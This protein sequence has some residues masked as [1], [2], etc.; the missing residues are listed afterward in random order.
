MKKI[1]VFTCLSILLLSSEAAWAAD[2]S[3]QTSIL[4]DINSLINTNP[5]LSAVVL[6]VFIILL[7]VVTLRYTRSRKKRGK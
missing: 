5:I 1:I 7:E 4:K 3:S 6:L 2:T